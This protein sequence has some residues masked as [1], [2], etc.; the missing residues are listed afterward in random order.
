MRKYL[1]DLHQMDDGMLQR[2]SIHHQLGLAKEVICCH[3][4]TLQDPEHGKARGNLELEA[5]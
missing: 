3:S 2:Y 5:G 4:D 1:I